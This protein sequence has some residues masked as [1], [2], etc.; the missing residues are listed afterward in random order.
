VRGGKAV[1][2][3]ILEELYQNYYDAAYAYTLSLCKNRE[4]TED[5]VADAFVKALFSYENETEHFQYWLLL[6]CK[7]LWIDRLRRKQK[8]MELQTELPI[9]A[10]PEQSPE[11]QSINRERNRMLLQCI[12]SFPPHYREALL[13]YY[14]AGLSTGEIA[15]IMQR[16]VGNVKTTLCRGR[17]KLKKALEESGYGF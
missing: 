15:K 5:L 12:Y 9:Y 11:T 4:D 6:V 17:I 8:Q 3:D 14:Y 13:L 16:S 2:P 10:P 7:N 1:Q